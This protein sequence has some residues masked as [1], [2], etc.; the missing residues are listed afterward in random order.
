MSG[1]RYLNTPQV[2]EV[3]CADSS[4]ASESDNGSATV[5]VTVQPVT[6][7]AGSFQV[8]APPVSNNSTV[9]R[10]AIIHYDL[11]PANILFDEFGDVKITGIL[12]CDG[13]LIKF[14]YYVHIDFGLSKVIDDSN[15]SDGDNGSVE[16]TSIGAGTYWY[17][18]PECFV[19]IGNNPGA[20]LNN[21]SS[22]A[23]R[24][25]S[26]VDV[27][28]VGI[29]YYQ[30]LYGK[31]PFGEGKTQEVI[32]K[33]GTILAANQVDFPTASANTT[34]AGSIHYIPKV[35]DE[36]KEFIRLCLAHDQNYRP[37]VQAL[38]QHPYLKKK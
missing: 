29:I 20:N 32:L 10:K 30:M 13:S 38:C 23:P 22:N 37:D 7:P 36:G 31:R 27:W 16:L 25:S 8:N 9:R 1:L 28:S 19:G 21:S 18:P 6:E 33:E 24:I 3:I 35:T 12:N 14:L 34:S 4:V 11:K 5:P 15:S 2:V 26:K 17:L